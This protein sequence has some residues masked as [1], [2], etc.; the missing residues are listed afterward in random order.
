MENVQMTL[1][2]LQQ[3]PMSTCVQSRGASGLY[4]NVEAVCGVCVRRRLLPMF[5]VLS[6]DAHFLDYKFKELLL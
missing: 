3:Y 1:P 6:P 4:A 5:L 2:Q